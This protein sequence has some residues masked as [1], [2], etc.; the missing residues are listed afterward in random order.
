VADLYGS[1][2]EIKARGQ[3]IVGLVQ[4]DVGHL[5]IFVSGKV[6]K[7]EYTQL[8]SVLET[9]ERLPPGLY[10]MNIIESK[11]E[12]GKTEYQVEFQERR[13]EDVLKHVNRFQRQD[14]RPFEAVEA[15]SEFNQRAYEMFAQPL[16]QATSTEYGAQLMR[17]FHPLRLQR[18][19]MSDMN[20]WS[21]WLGPVAEAVRAHRQPAEPEHPLRQVEAVGSEL[22]S[23]GLDFYRAMRD[24]TVESM[25][26][27]VY[28]NLFSMYL[29]DKRETEQKIPQVGEPRDLP[30]VREALDAVDR[31]GY[32]EAFARSG[33]LLMRHDQPLP[34]SRLVMTA[35]L[36]RDY[37]EYLPKVAPEDLRRMRGEQEIIVRYEPEQA[38]LTLPSLLRDT[39]DRMRLV[40]LLDKLIHDPRVQAVQPTQEQ[41]AMVERVRSVLAPRPVVTAERVGAE[42]K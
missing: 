35:E 22:L 37:A 14:E 31:G 13:L 28:A 11:G 5:G 21:A 23:A 39:G 9:I 3:V 16:V 32:A 12:G 1:T 8:V 42:V 6:A 20:P 29:A 33:A 18:W 24:A 19:A 27:G 25:F 30:Y 2:E 26:F 36:A 10:A 4:Q 7:K 15:M 38:V 34:L 17:Q 40:T 41:L